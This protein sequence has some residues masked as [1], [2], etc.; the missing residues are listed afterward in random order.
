LKEKGTPCISLEVQVV[1]VEKQRVSEKTGEE[2]T[3]KWE[4]NI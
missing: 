2:I 3:L 1:K 4:E